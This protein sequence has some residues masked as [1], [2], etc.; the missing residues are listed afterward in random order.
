MLS[1]AQDDS[2]RLRLTESPQKPSNQDS[3]A[4]WQ[5][6]RRATAEQLGERW[7]GFG[8]AGAAAIRTGFGGVASG[9]ACCD[10]VL[11]K[12]PAQ[13]IYITQDGVH[14]RPLP[15]IVER[16]LSIRDLHPVRKWMLRQPWGLA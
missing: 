15:R 8:L 13:A 5:P 16:A 7:D 9:A 1:G 14:S 2:A 12:R 11:W 6:E 10:R 4:A 3:L